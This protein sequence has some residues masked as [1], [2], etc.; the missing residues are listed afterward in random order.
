[1]KAHT[2]SLP[3]V[4]LTRPVLTSLGCP[5][6]SVPP[7]ADIGC[8]KTALVGACK[9][10]LVDTNRT[11]DHNRVRAELVKLK[12]F[13][14]KWCKRNLTPLSCD[15]DI[16]FDTWIENTNYSLKQRTQLRELYEEQI[17]R[18]EKVLVQDKR[19]TK[20]KSFVK[21]EHY[22][23]YKHA[24]SIN[25]RSDTF[26]VL[27]GPIFKAIEKE[28]FAKE[29]FIKKVPVSDRP[30]LIA[31]ALVAG[32]F[33]FASDYSAFE[34][35]FTKE[36]MKSVEF[37]MYK[38]MVKHLNVPWF[39]DALYSVL[40]G[41]NHCSYRDFSLNVEATRMSGEMCTS[42]G[43]GFTNLMVILYL[44]EKMNNPVRCWIEGDDCLAFWKN[45]EMPTAAHFRDVG[46]DV[47]VETFENPSEA[48]FCGMVFSPET[49][50]VITD[51]V[52][53]L[54]T[55]GWGN[56]KY[57][58]SNRKVKNALLRAKSLSILAQYP[59]CPI[60]ES[61]GHYGARVTAGINVCNKVIE[62][63]DSYKREQI[64]HALSLSR[65]TTKRTVAIEDRALMQKLFGVSI[66]HQLSIEN[67]LDN[68]EE[69]TPL[70]LPDLDMITHPDW[71]HFWMNYAGSDDWQ[72]PPELFDDYSDV[73][74]PLF[75]GRVPWFLRES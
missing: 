4:V 69:I 15:T 46:F 27:T 9:R 21:L 25:S 32:D 38:Y 56:G 40:A 42:L 52:Y 49:K 31:E 22:T 60:L 51:P 55:F 1:M 65:P 34:A 23:E 74:R 6:E 36:L 8:P 64:L 75:K 62:G 43:N 33:G 2:A 72:R 66:D 47:K 61:L 67:Y 5:S 48:S 35:H 26:K 30:A 18:G 19:V 20:V 10:F 45:R 11:K 57:H 3:R 73:V 71:V 63:F 41:T 53:V 17:F 13:V 59:G 14:R 12:N 28:V 37:V 70:R 16:S 50:T 44:S 58:K 54:S 7:V 24:R 39:V 68:L 29:W